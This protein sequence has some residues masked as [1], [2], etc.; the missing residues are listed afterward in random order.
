MN[1]I[2]IA[3]AGGRTAIEV[4]GKVYGP[5]IEEIEFSQD[6]CSHPKLT[7]TVDLVDF[8]EAGYTL[9]RF[10]EVQQERERRRLAAGAIEPQ[11]ESAKKP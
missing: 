4:N 3:S 10:V 5:G 1:T 2:R 9:E 7:V 8:R 11:P 6:G